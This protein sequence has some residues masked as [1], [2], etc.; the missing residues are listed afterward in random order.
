MFKA[1]ENV[2]SYQERLGFIEAASYEMN[3]GLILPVKLIT[4]N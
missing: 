4:A 2:F 1:N 3:S